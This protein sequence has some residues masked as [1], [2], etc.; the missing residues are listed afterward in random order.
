MYEP[1]FERSFS[2]GVDWERFATAVDGPLQTDYL[3]RAKNAYEAALDLNHE[4]VVVHINL[5]TVLTKLGEFEKAMEVYLRGTRLEPNHVL[6]FQAANLAHNMK[7]ERAEHFFQEC[8]RYGG[9]Y[10]ARVNYGAILQ[11]NGRFKE[12]EENYF[13]ALEGAIPDATREQLY[14]YLAMMYQ[15][16]GETEKAKMYYVKVILV[17]TDRI[18]TITSS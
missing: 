15:E 8:I 5:G 3:T 11:V 10:M 13:A 17:Q 12:A 2:E 7:D 9:G 1:S 14:G 4:N 16:M 6:L 18:R